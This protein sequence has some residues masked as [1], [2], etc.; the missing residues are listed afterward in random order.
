MKNSRCPDTSV[1]PEATEMNMNMD[2]N[3]G[4]C[5][6]QMGCCAPQTMMCPPVYECPQV[7]CC[8]RVINYE[9]PQV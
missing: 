4:C 5:M 9:V 7:R 3:M 1:F 6:P 8:H 2:M